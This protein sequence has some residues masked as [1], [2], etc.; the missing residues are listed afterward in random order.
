MELKMLES[1]KSYFCLDDEIEKLLKTKEQKDRNKILK[2]I[3]N[4]DNGAIKIVYI[5][6]NI[7]LNDKDI[8]NIFNLL[9]NL[10]SDKYPIYEILNLLHSNNAEIRNQG[11]ELLKE[12]DNNI[13][14]NI[15]KELITED[16]SFTLLAFKILGGVSI[17]DK[18][19]YILEL[20]E[21][22]ENVDVAMNAVEY[23]QN[24]A[25]ARDIMILNQLKEKFK[26]SKYASFTIDLAIDNI[27]KNNI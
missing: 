6:I 4:S 19:D 12:Y 3:I 16:S 26:N 13:I 7:N 2:N 21:N 27:S 17:D 23:L 24:I 8:K 20:L 1:I 15:V 10:D 18:R 5:L 11:I 9:E 25:E 14:S 22:E